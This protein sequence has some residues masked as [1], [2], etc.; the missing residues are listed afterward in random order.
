METAENNAGKSLLK[1][2]L[3]DGGRFT[4]FE[5]LKDPVCIISTDGILVYGNGPF[6][7]VF[8]P[9]DIHHRISLQHPFSSEYRKRLAQAYLNALNGNDN[10][11]FVVINSPDGKEMPL[12]LYLFPLFGESGLRN[13]LVL[14]RV[15][16]SRASSIERSA[17]QQL[18]EESI[19]YDNQ[20]LEFSPLPILRLDRGMNIIRCSESIEGFLGYSCEDLT[21]KKTATIRNIFL[22]DADRIRNTA[23]EIF[24]GGRPFNRKGE[25]KMVTK[26]S[27]EKLVNLTFYPLMNKN[28]INAVEIIIENITELK[29]LKEKINSINRIQL[30]QD[31]TKGFLHSLNNSINII[32]SQTQM[33]LQ[34]TEKESVLDGIHIIERSALDIV[35]NIRRVQNSIAKKS[36]FYEERT[37]PLVNIIEDAI[38]FSRMQFK[39]EDKEKKRNIIIDK[40]YFTAVNIRIDTGLLREIIISIILKVSAF[41]RKKGVIEISL[42]DN[43]DLM[44]I[45]KVNKEDRNVDTLHLQK[46]VNVF[47]GIDIRQAAEKISIKIIEEESSE[48]YAIKAVFPQ[49]LITDKLN[50]PPTEPDIKLRDLDIIIVEDEKALKKILF[51]IF[52]RM[53]NRVFICDNGNEALEEFRRKHYDIVI[54]DYGIPGITGIELAVRVKELRED[55]LTVL[56]S[57]WTLEG[58]TAYRSIVDMFM[59]KPFKLDDLIN[60]I[61]QVLKEKR[62]QKDG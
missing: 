52:D 21:E 36:Y 22:Y 15:L 43:N 31:I 5:S 48:S 17:I 57:G 14:L 33:L 26:E 19:Q 23:L 62:K 12:E 16:D 42:K 27:E 46:M 44:L 49:R 3:E 40:K 54:T 25:I 7:Q 1:P 8:G 24:E 6:H 50:L 4:I 2:D 18:S 37:E 30:L 58:L 41:I 10:R 47:S 20:H 34:I 56:L 35:D 55:V 59:P 32:M 28:E 11:C 60:S 39:V 9:G 38:E 29:S 45:I 13:I 51:E 61:S 53:G